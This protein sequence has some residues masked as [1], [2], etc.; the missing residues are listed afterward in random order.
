M[1][2]FSEKKHIMLTSLDVYAHVHVNEILIF[3]KFINMCF[4]S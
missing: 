2:Y 3:L 1:Q 4:H